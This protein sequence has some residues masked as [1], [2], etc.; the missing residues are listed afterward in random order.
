MKNTRSLRHQKNRSPDPKDENNSEMVVNAHSN[1]ERAEDAPSETVV[2]PEE[3]GIGEENGVD[4][5]G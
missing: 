5:Q 4:R 2:D 1:Q 3:I